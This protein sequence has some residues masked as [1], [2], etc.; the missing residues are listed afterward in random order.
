MGAMLVK[1]GTVG[2]KYMIDQCLPTAGQ[3]IAPF[4]APL[5]AIYI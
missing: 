5:V 1:K 2:A 4:G 3:V